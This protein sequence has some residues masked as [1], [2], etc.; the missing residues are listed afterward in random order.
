MLLTIFLEATRN[1]TFIAEN[2]LL[3]IKWNSAHFSE[4]LDCDMAS[5]ADSI[6]RIIV[7]SN[8]FR[9]SQLN[10]FIQIELINHGTKRRSIV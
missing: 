9:T 2:H 8:A 7:F 4:S 3:E 5:N 6:P 1:N 10:V